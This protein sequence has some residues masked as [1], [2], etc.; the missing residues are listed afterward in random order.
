[1]A[2]DLLYSLGLDI[3]DFKTSAKATKES[4][5]DIKRS[6]KGIKD[7]IGAGGVGAAVLGFFSSVVNY[8]QAAKGELD[9]NTRAVKEFGD[10]IDGLKEGATKMGVVV[11]GAFN[12]MGAAIG[13]AINIARVGWSQ[14]AQDQDALTA[15]TAAAEAAEARLAEAKKKSGTEFAKISADLL[16]VKKQ[17]ADLANQG[18]TTQETY[19]KMFNAY[20]ALVAKQANFSGDAIEK[21]RIELELANA[22]LD[23]EKALLAVN[24]DQAGEKKKADEAADKALEKTIGD[25]NKLGDIKRKQLDYERSKQPLEEQSGRLTAEKLA[26]ET[27]LLDKTISIT[28]E[29]ETRARLL[30]IIK[31]LDATGVKLAEEKLALERR[32]TAEKEKQITLSYQASEGTDTQ[33]LSDRQLEQ[34]RRALLTAASRARQATPSYAGDDGGAGFIE[35]RIRQ[36]QEEISTRS[37]FRNDYAA[38]GE[39]ALN[40]YSA[41]EED[42]YRRYITP[43]DQQRAKDQAEATKKIANLLTGLFGTRG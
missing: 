33:T 32:L 25:F 16:A 39:K 38:N 35:N 6:F 26:L 37:R 40:N 29:T 13:D 5:D 10:G 22:H 24:K 7:I 19:N 28:D 3:T 36:I 41:N 42:R 4:A 43:E 31:T 8:A 27:R 17:E 1:M 9:A 34:Q 30:E 14:W 15:S 20:L 11:L 21:R 23:K 12:R 2:S 18:L